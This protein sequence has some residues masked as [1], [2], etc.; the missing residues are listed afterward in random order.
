[1]FLL[2][3]SLPTPLRIHG[4]MIEG[5]VI[6]E[7]SELEGIRKGYSG[8]MLIRNSGYISNPGSIDLRTGNRDLRFLKGK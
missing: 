2:G 3:K 1:M 6:E 5:S 8:L 7:I 4:F